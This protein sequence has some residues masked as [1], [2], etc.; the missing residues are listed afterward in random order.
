MDTTCFTPSQSAG[1]AKATAQSFSCGRRARVGT[2]RNVRVELV[3][4]GEAVQAREVVADGSWK[5]VSFEQEIDDS[6]WVALR[7]LASSH[8]NPIFVLVKDAPI[9]ASRASAEWCRKAVDRCWDMK[10][11]KIREAERE[12]AR[13]AYDHARR[14]YDRIIEESRD[15]SSR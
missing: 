9:R 6:S 15:R 12:A 5:D 8:T 3:L 11:P 13:E 7:I 14:T 2:T 4:N 1:T 10:L